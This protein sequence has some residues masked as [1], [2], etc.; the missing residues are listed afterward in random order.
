M[1]E[2]R[3]LS[4]RFGARLALDR[5]SFRA[6]PGRVTAFLGPNGSGKTTT[7]RVIL[8]LDAPTSG[9]ALVDGVPYPT[10]GAPLRHLGALLDA[11]AVHPG[12]SAFDHLRSLAL[13]HRIPDTRVDDVL[14]SVGLSEVAGQRVGGFS[15]GMRQRLGIAAAM[16]GD[17]RTYIF[18]E[19]L[20]GLD[21]EG[22]QW[23]RRFVRA[24]VADDAA[25]LLSSHLIS[26]LELIADDVVIIGRGRVLVESPLRDLP[27]A[28][29]GAP[30]A[31][32]ATTSRLGDLAAAIA[33]DGGRATTEGRSLRVTGLTARDIGGIAAAAGIP[34][35][36]LRLEPQSLESA[37]QE[38]T[39]RHVEYSAPEGP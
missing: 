6:L 24:L 33:E 37:Y 9:E 13:T 16:L 19:P 10:L 27:D 12:R 1:I 18:D 25:V 4:K 39:R 3:E 5:V 22:V 31:V 7:M 30:A 17:P 21:P 26:E 38:I 36:E 2:V 34:L 23:F 15:L 35:E 14:E 29:R 28:V 11:G 32:L 8:G 20:N